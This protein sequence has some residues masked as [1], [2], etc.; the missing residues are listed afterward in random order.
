MGATEE[1]LLDLADEDETSSDKPTTLYRLFDENGV[2]PYVGIAGNPGRRL[3]QHAK[4]KRWWD[5]VETVRLKHFP[6]R[7]A[8]VD[9]EGKAI[10]AERPRHNIA[11]TTHQGPKRGRGRAARTPFRLPQKVAG[12]KKR[13]IRRHPHGGGCSFTWGCA[14]GSGSYHPAGTHVDCPDPDGCCCTCHD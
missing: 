2:L 12:A 13:T 10:R 14:S 4:T 7:A 11:M 1:R 6:S 9:A 8:A 3:E 5:E